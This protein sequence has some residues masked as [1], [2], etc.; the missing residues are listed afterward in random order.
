MKVNPIAV[1]GKQLIHQNVIPCARRWR[2]Q[3]LPRHLQLNRSQPA[4]LATSCP[5]FFRRFS[6]H[7]LAVSLRLHRSAS[8]ALLCWSQAF[9]SAVE[10]PDLVS[11]ARVRR[12]RH[13]F[14]SLALSGIALV[15]NVCLPLRHCSLSGRTLLPASTEV[16]TFEIAQLAP[17][18]PGKAV[19]FSRAVN[20]RLQSTTAARDKKT[21]FSRDLHGTGGIAKDIRGQ[22]HQRPKADSSACAGGLRCWCRKRD[23]N[24]RPRHYE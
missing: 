7:F 2:A 22:R 1:S 20:T 17:K 5:H 3:A 21:L 9:L 19:R 8:L 10:P 23:S 12:L 16:L 18:P 6:V 13:Q 14:A 11:R 15:R 24:P 4:P